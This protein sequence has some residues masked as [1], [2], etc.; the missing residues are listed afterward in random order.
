M[1]LSFSEVNFLTSHPQFKGNFDPESP[2]A[3]TLLGEY[4]AILAV[5]CPLFQP[6]VYVP[7][8]LTEK[9]P[10]VH[11][12][13]SAWEIEK[14][15]PVKIGVWGDIKIGLQALDVSLKRLISSSWQ[16]AAKRRAAEMGA[17]KSRTRVTYLERVRENWE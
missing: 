2:K 15:V 6:F 4:D 16:E 7:R 9:H 5:G 10:I 12:D 13:V 14:N 1:A 11:L 17:L 8:V 3:Q